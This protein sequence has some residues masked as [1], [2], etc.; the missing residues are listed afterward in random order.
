MRF[1]H[2]FIATVFVLFAGVQ[3]ND[4]DPWLWVLVYLGVSIC[5]IAHLVKRDLKWLSLLGAVGCLVGVIMIAPDFLQWL[6]DGMPSIVKSMKAET[7]Y[8]ELV[9][10]FLG[11]LL[12]GIAYAYYYLKMRRTLT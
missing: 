10:E 9:R 5:A 11:Y 6:K 1:L 3:L 2:I 4:P 12:A 8:I 7:P